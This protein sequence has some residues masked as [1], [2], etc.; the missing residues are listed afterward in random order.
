MHINIQPIEKQT[1]LDTIQIHSIFPTIQGEGPFCGH[2]A[3]FIRLAGCNLQ[4]PKCD[5]DYTSIRIPL[6]VNE[7]RQKIDIH[8][9]HWNC[10]LIVITGGEPFRQNIAPLI[11]ILVSLGYHVQ[12]ETNGS[13]FV[14]GVPWDSITVICSPKTAKLNAQLQ[15]HIDYYKYVLSYD[16]VDE[17]DG[18]PI[19][20][21]GHSVKG[22]IARPHYKDNIF[23]HRVPIYLQPADE[24]GTHIN[25][26]QR[27]LSA[28]VQSC[29][30]YG[31][32][33]QLQI[34]KLIGV[35]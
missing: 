29:M 26:N 4:C 22:R 35:P 28:C 25:I 3:I 24:P 7:I 2:R 6:T 5:T 17:T 32:I 9:V 12:I 33:L 8:C 1:L 20:A 23:D 18:L 27:N 13:L 34:H 16:N 10:K 11:R 31:Y 30:K 19:R 15:A 21:L 14:E